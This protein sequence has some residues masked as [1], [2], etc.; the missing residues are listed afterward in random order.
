MLFY[1]IPGPAN[2]ELILLF[3][4]VVGD[5]VE[6]RSGCGVRGPTDGINMVLLIFVYFPEDLW[7]ATTYNM[8]WSSCIL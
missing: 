1:T 2:P 5:D 8:V 6:E 3:S 7:L 4:T